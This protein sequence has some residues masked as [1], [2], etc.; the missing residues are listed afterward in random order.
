MDVIRE[1]RLVI[2]GVRELLL[3]INRDFSFYSLDEIKL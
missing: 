1:K 2:G 3:Q